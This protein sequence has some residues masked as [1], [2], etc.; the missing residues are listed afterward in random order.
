MLPEYDGTGVVSSPLLDTV[1]SV[2]ST[3]P[4]VLDRVRDVLGAYALVCTPIDQED[5]P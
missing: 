1:Y 4:H 5:P 2:C 3:Q